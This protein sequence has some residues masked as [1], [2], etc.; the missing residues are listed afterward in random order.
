MSVTLTSPP[1]ELSFSA[2]KITAGFT[3]V[4]IYEQIGVKAINTVPIP[5]AAPGVSVIL[6]YG[7]ETITMVASMTPDDSGTQ[8][9]ATDGMLVIPI[10]VQIEYF[11]ANYILSRD[12]DIVVDPGGSSSIIFTA[13]NTGLGYNMVTFNTTAGV[14]EVVKP[15]YGLQFRLFIEKPDYTGFQL[16]NTAAPTIQ[17]GDTTTAEAIIGDKLHDFINAEI[18]NN[19]P[20]I[21][22][23]LPL[24]CKKSCRRYYFEFAESYGD[25]IQI[26]KVFTSPIFTVLHGGLSYIGQGTKNIADII[27]PDPDSRKRFLKQGGNITS[28]RSNQ[29]QYLYYYNLDAS[30]SASLK[31]RLRFTNGD[32]VQVALHNFS[33]ME[34][35]KYAFNISFEKIYNQNDYPGKTLLGY[36]IWITSEDGTR[37]TE[38]QTY[39]IDYRPLPYI[40][41]FLNW[42][43]W[44]SFDSRMFYGKGSSTFD[45]VQSEAMKSELAPSDLKMG[46]S[47][48]YDIKLTSKLSVTTGFIK[49]RSSLIFNRDFFLSPLK[50]RVAG[51]YLLPIKVTSKSIPE[52]EDGNSLY[53]QKFDY[54]YLFDDQ[55]FT[56]GDVQEPGIV[57][58]DNFTGFTNIYLTDKEYKFL[59]TSIN[60][61]LITI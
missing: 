10:F 37:L 3:C 43:S 47:L 36:E 46:T 53:A 35:R 51:D 17:I 49:N 34:K 42:S 32:S 31:C 8:F 26:R 20:D 19:L 50:Y 56:E 58:E 60:H 38:T 14:A 27:M 1:P 12:F 16:I 13:K 29:L 24:L 2:D 5:D 59:A 28:T 25:P 4:G 18:R 6:K 11:K 7:N 39:L 30:F 41:Y 48:V 61:D 54:E 57:F 33:M 15:N 21:P 55:A 45:I 52:I 23:S 44:G 22:D 40:R 9:Q